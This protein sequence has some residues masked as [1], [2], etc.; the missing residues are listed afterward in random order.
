MPSATITVQNNHATL[1]LVGGRTVFLV[2]DHAALV[3]AGISRADGNDLRVISSVM[4]ELEVH[5]SSPNTAA[6]LVF[7]SL[8]ADIA[9]LSSS[10]AYTLAYGDLGRRSPYPVPI[11]DKSQ[12][13]PISNGYRLRRTQP[14]LFFDDFG[15]K[16]TGSGYAAYGAAEALST[17]F[18]TVV[19]TWTCTANVLATAGG[20]ASHITLKGTALNALALRTRVL[21]AIDPAATTPVVGASFHDTGSAAL[22]LYVVG[23]G[24][25]DVLAVMGKFVAGAPT[26]LAGPT[27]TATLS[28]PSLIT[29]TLRPSGADLYI[30]GTVGTAVIAETLISSPDF[31]TGG[32]G[33]VSTTAGGGFLVFQ[34]FAVELWDGVPDGSVVVSAS[35]PALTLPCPGFPQE[36]VGVI[37]QAAAYP[38]YFST[39]RVRIHPGR[40]G[41][42]SL[43]WDALAPEE[44]YEIKAFVAEKRGSC[45]VFSWTPPDDTAGTFRVAPASYRPV[46]V[47]HGDL[48]AT[49]DLERVHQ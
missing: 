33:I 2:L 23:S 3:T 32:A 5:V 38:D 6:C 34:N 42:Y 41:G 25:S 26:V 28:L 15:W 20:V 19:G 12:W 1:P 8:Q 24:L 43:A 48:R 16:W 13:S 10:T 44:F 14:F 49:L 31:P 11:R 39:R 7:F 46:R 36:I 18:Y 9:N 47:R 35:I 29:A 27:A 40:A 37:A 21:F 22:N 4:G 45:A 30:G 17:S